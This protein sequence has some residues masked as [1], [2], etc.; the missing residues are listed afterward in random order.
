[1]G[2]YFTV[3][4]G[5]RR[6]T[7]QTKTTVYIKPSA[8]SRQTSKFILISWA[9]NCSM[10]IL[11]IIHLKDYENSRLYQLPHILYGIKYNLRLSIKS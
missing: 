11:F 4:G 6:P 10:G 3:I 2:L 5:Q 9:F 1:M 7:G 8:T